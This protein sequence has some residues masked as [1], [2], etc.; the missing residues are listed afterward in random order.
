MAQRA[1]QWLHDA[2]ARS[3]RRYSCCSGARGASLLS[4]AALNAV[5]AVSRRMAATMEVELAR[6][7][8][9]RCSRFARRRRGRSTESTSAW[10]CFGPSAAAGFAEMRCP[11]P[12]STNGMSLA[13]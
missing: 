13:K 10:L 12:S 4:V 2:A 11:S 3:A 5:S 8:P 9:R 1:L 7:S 6:V